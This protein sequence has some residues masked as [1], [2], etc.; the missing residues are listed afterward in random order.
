MQSQEAY[1]QNEAIQIGRHAKTLPEQVAEHLMKAIQEGIIEPG[2]RMK[3]ETYSERFAVSRSTIREAM[4][5]LEKRGIVE[6]IPRYGV[7]VTAYDPREIEHIFLIRSQLLGLAASQV[8]QSHPADV[9]D[10]LVAGVD[11]LKQLSLDAKTKP[12]DY[13][14][15]S[16]H[17]Q[18]ILMAASGIKMLHSMYEALSDQALWRFAIREKAI[19][20]LTQKRRKQ[21]AADW[22]KVVSHIVKGE[23]DQAERAARALLLASYQAVKEVLQKKE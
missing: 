2:E 8:A 13:M 9:K 18:R 14:E 10:Q 20:F 1:F 11:R 5:L 15:I 16:V 3:E 19:S 17:M 7:R 22:D 23:A 6:R 21:S 4:S 12:V